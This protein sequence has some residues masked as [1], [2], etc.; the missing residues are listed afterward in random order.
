MPQPYLPERKERGAAGFAES[1]PLFALRKNQSALDRYGSRNGRVLRPVNSLGYRSIYWSIDSLDCVGEERLCRF[2]HC[3]AYP[4]SGDRTAQSY[5]ARRLSNDSGSVAPDA[6]ALRS[7]GVFISSPF[8]A[9]IRSAPQWACRSLARPCTRIC[10]RAT[11]FL[12]VDSQMRRRL[13]KIAL[14]LR[15]SIGF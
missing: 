9:L 11:M 12:F 14:S 15:K 2:I 1:A 4:P 13:R 5:C 8:P 10:A 6:P 3:I 7:S